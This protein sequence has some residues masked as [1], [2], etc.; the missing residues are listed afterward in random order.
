MR[1]MSAAGVGSPRFLLVSGNN[2]LIHGKEISYHLCGQRPLLFHVFALLMRLWLIATWSSRKIFGTKTR[3][4]HL[5]CPS[6]AWRLSAVH[7][8]YSGF[9]FSTTP[10]A[11]HL[12]SRALQLH[13]LMAYIIIQL[14]VQPASLSS[15]LHHDFRQEI[16]T[17]TITRNLHYNGPIS[18]IHCVTVRTEQISQSGKAR[19]YSVDKALSL[20]RHPPC[21]TLR[22]P[23]CGLVW[24]I[25]WHYVL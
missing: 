14:D 15:N 11:P 18:V 19:L 6:W 8:T 24:F 3:F 10:R 7:C 9:I 23:I 12:T 13:L 4:P 16:A 2:T 17:N 5:S 20:F 21:V 1:I 22:N 25:L